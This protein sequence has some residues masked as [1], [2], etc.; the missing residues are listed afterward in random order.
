MTPKEAIIKYFCV[1]DIEMLEMILDDSYTYHEARKDVFL[2][3][4]NEVFDKF[5]KEGDTELLIHEGE[6]NS[7]HCNLGKKGYCFVGNNSRQYICFFFEGDGTNVTNICRCC[8]FKTDVPEVVD[9]GGI[10]FIIGEDEK[11]DFVP[12]SWY[13]ETIRKCEDAYNELLQDGIAYLSK[14]DYVDWLKRYES[15]HDKTA[16]P[17]D[18][19]QGFEKF[20]KLYSNI[21]VVASFLEYE[22]YAE[23][24]MKDFLK[25][26]PTKDEHLLQWLLKY[27][28]WVPKL[29]YFNCFSN[30]EKIKDGY[31]DISEENNVFLLVEDYKNLIDFKSSFDEYD[32]AMQHKYFLISSEEWEIIEKEADENDDTSTLKFHLKRSG[33]LDEMGK[34]RIKPD[35]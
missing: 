17:F 33:M 34:V 35:R 30:K 22:N 4:L 23:Q 1:M 6:C 14:E 25:I 18:Y 12:S 19:Y 7:K 32:Y 27:E 20:N 2:K 21:R 26:D 15:F 24:A 5:K 13:I 31:L 29:K 3:K 16:T 10:S 8:E 28:D 11:A 9:Y